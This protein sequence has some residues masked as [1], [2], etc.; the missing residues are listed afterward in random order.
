[1]RD[2]FFL[3]FAFVHARLPSDATPSPKNFKETLA[4][5]GESER[6]R[7]HDGTNRAG[8]CRLKN[9]FVVT[10]ARNGRGALSKRLDLHREFYFCPPRRFISP[11]S[12]AESYEKKCNDF[13]GSEITGSIKNL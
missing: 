8:K 2:S 7:E 12:Y 11:H 10:A 9:D 4:L 13:H 3:S 1:M 5:G 6:E